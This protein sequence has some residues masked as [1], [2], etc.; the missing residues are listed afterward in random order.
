[1][2]EVYTFYINP[3]TDIRY[4]ID[5]FTIVLIFRFFSNNGAFF[6]IFPFAQ[7]I[8]NKLGICTV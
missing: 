2:H 5:D 1:M 3:F 6:S 7:G 4:L 8:K